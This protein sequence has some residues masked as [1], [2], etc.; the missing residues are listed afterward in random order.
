MQNFR[1][2]QVWQKAHELVLHIYELT[3]DFPREELFGLRT[4]LRK[5]AVDVAGYIAEGSGKS[6]DDEFAKCIAISLG[7]ASRL[8]YFALVAFDLKLL[9]DT[10]Y[11]PLN[12]RIVE[13]S[14][15]LGAFLQTLRRSGRNSIDN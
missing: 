13:V 10:V 11:E 8:E 1:N 5:T 9:P 12:E 4:Q 6:N 15:M 14:K 2:V 7:I 3:A